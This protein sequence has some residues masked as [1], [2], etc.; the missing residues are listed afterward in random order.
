MP[1]EADAQVVLLLGE[2]VA[3]VLSAAAATDHIGVASFSNT[4]L[5]TAAEG[6][7]ERYPRAEIIVLADLHKTSGEPDRFAID[8]ASRC[9]GKLAVPRFGQSRAPHQKDFND[10]AVANGHAAIAECIATASSVSLVAV[11]KSEKRDEAIVELVCAADLEPEAISWLW[12]GFIAHRKL[13]M[14]AGAPGTGKTTIALSL[15][16]TVSSGGIWPDG[17]RSPVGDV[18][19]WSG[20]DGTNDV[21]VPRLLACGADR[22]RVHF[23][24]PVTQSGVKRDFDPAKD[25]EALA[26]ALGQLSSGGLLIVDPIVSAISGDSHKNAEVRRSLQPLVNLAADKG[27]A[28]LGITHFSKGTAGRDPLERLTGS[29]AFGAL[30]RCVMVTVKPTQ[31]EGD[32][33][34]L[35]TFVRAKSNI[36]EDGG[37]FEYSLNAIALEDFAGI[38]TT[39][40]VWGKAVTGTAQAL[41]AKVEGGG[42][43]E[44]ETALAG[45]KSFLTEILSSGPL[46]FMD[47]KAAADAAGISIATVRRGKNALGVRAIKS[48]MKDGWIWSLSRRC[49]ESAEE[50]QQGKLSIFG[51]SEHLR[52]EPD[53]NSPEE[54]F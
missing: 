29:L 30:A 18:I 36:G 33:P 34:K 43:E 15:A 53:D 6:L 2:G 16:A 5:P 21:L 4:N 46:P 12:P 50:G 24:G 51:K 32:A 41:L 10:M 25:M 35:R 13:S 45:A 11:L 8:A 19:I 3:T 42:C 52:T 26:D 7:R 17:M 20:E 47:V 40:V 9:A 14:L 48:G 28:V 22:L 27:C 39:Q 38:T 1:A 37:G 49:S 54:G 44:R 31:A 23:V